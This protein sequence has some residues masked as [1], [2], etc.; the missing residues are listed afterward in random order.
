MASPGSDRR[1]APKRRLAAVALAASVALGGCEGVDVGDLESAIASFLPSGLPEFSIPPI[2]PSDP[3]ATGLVPTE[4]APTEPPATAPPAT[5]APPVSEP[6]ATPPPT[7]ASTPEPTPEPTPAPTAE[8]T[9]EPTATP[10]PGPSAS[11]TP[12]EGE[13]AADQAPLLIGLI[14]LAVLVGALVAST[15]LRRRAAWRRTAARLGLDAGS[16]ADLAL[17]TPRQP[18]AGAEAAWLATREDAGRRLTALDLPVRD[19]LAGAPGPPERRRAEA[20]LTAL[21][22]LRS[23]LATDD[24]L[25]LA[26]P[27]PTTEQ[28]GL[29]QAILG[30]RATE[31]RAAADALRSI[32][33][34]AGSA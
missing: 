12:I 10:S 18:T 31:L 26:S 34:R 9:P 23:A 19:L 22:G 16:A 17:A 13:P 1:R 30:R 6:P 21:D 8:P 7:A 33:G 25:Q 24:A 4:P 29:S 14:L 28:R 15:I 11:P 5:D 27:P 32:E 3:P 2:F 20:L